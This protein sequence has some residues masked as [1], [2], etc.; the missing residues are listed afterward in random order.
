M[1][2]KVEKIEN[3]QEPE[4]KDFNPNSINVE[5][6]QTEIPDPEPVKPEPVKKRTYTKRTTKDKLEI[7]ITGESLNPAVGFFNNVLISRFGDPVALN[8]N[9]I[10]AISNAVAAVA[11]KYL[12]STVS[13][14]GEE[15]TLLI[16]L[17]TVGADKYVRYQMSK[18]NP[19]ETE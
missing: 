15:L 14:Y 1:S 19:S 6:I 9:E 17:T 4:K 16:L 2:K 8:K 11:T 18:P 13:K 5:S 3:G 10:E 7:T 12:P